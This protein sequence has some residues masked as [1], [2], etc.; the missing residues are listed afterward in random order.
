MLPDFTNMACGQPFNVVIK[1]YER[2][3]TWILSSR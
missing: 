2:N 1:R 3:T